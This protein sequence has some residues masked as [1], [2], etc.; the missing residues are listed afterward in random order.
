MDPAPDFSRHVPAHGYAWWYVDAWSDD[1]DFGLTMI[2]FIGSVFSPYYAWSGREDP[3]NHCAI[4]VALYG[5][6][7]R[8]WAMTERGRGRVRRDAT[9]FHVGPSH[10]AWD[11]EGLTITVAERAMPVPRKVAG[12]IRVHPEILNSQSF[13]LDDAERHRWRPV[14]PRARVELDFS[15]PGLSWSGD[16]YFDSNS[17][18]EPLE[19]GFRYWDW[20]R[21]ALGQDRAAIL[22]NTDPMRGGRHQ[23]ALDFGPDG[24]ASIDAPLTDFALKPSPVFRN[25]R[26]TRAD[27]GAAPHIFETLEDAPFYSRSLLSSQIRGETLQGFH[28]G[29]SGPRFAATVTKLMLPFRMPRRA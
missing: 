27:P 11:G 14:A 6:R 29:F 5:R 12:T 24:A 26:R 9:H 15:H 25:R 16:G 13:A 17:G 22:Y 19:A 10:L 23:L 20:S 3:G 28:E 7:H 4:N 21:F 18:T 1:G 8:R 2:A